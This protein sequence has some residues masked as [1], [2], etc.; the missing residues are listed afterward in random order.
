MGFCVL[1]GTFE[2]SAACARGVAGLDM[3]LKAPRIALVSG[4][5]TSVSLSFGF[6]A[7]EIL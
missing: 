5:N 2:F 6:L 4:D 1:S 7:E 3:R